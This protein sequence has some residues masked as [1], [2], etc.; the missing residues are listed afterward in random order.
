M[1]DFRR[2]FKERG[3]MF[4]GDHFG[5]KYFDVASCVDCFYSQRG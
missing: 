1:L 4:L 3:T 2:V 5:M